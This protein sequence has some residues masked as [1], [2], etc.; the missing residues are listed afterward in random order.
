MTVILDMRMSFR[1]HARRSLV[2]PD[3]RRLPVNRHLS[4][5]EVALAIVL[6]LLVA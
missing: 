6:T 4:G 2:R 1:R 5:R 3:L